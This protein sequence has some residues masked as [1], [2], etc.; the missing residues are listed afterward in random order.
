MASSPDSAETRLTK[1]ILLSGNLI[2][3]KCLNG[4]FPGGAKI[5][6]LRTV[7]LTDSAHN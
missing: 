2:R 4:P 5:F 7:E 6:G 1:A 3:L